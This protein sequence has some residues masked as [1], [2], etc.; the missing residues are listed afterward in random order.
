M[1]M[2]DCSVV[3]LLFELESNATNYVHILGSEL[4]QFHFVIFHHL[5]CIFMY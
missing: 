4:L 3:R 2:S 1:V 5:D